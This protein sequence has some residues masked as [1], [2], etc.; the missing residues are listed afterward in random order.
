M[1]VFSTRSRFL[2]TQQRHYYTI[3]EVLHHQD[4]RETSFSNYPVNSAKSVNF[5]TE[6]FFERKKE[7]YE[8]QCAREI[9]QKYAGT[10]FSDRLKWQKW[11]LMM[12]W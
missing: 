6:I 3:G 4:F 8:K 11:S 10:R 5:K 12:K 2:A 7:I 9:T 1:V